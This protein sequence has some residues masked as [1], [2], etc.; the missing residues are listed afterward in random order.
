MKKTLV[1]L[2]V[3]ILLGLS[4]FNV[5]MATCQD[6]SITS[7]EQVE[8]QLKPMP[9]NLGRD[10]YYIENS[11]NEKMWL[12][13]EKQARY[14]GDFEISFYCSCEICNGTWTN[15]PCANGEPLQDGVTCAVDPNVI[16]LNSYIEIDGIGVRKAQDTGSYI[17]GNRIDVFLDDH[18]KCLEYGRKYDVK[19][20]MQKE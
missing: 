7:V 20:Y 6:V 15:Q 16:P 18:N 17:K 11:A 4:M 5:E 8:P 12:E 9:E 19:V 10:R 14:I 13:E 1:K 3:S 2:S